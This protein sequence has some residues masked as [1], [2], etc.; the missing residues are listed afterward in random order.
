MATLVQQLYN[1]VVLGGV[2]VLVALGITL[3]YGL[4]RLVNF[5][6]GQM[7]T[8]GAFI[9][10]SLVQLH[11]PLLVAIPLSMV[12]VALVGELL[13]LTLFRRTLHRPLSGLIISLGLIA[14]FEAFFVL[15]W[16]TNSYQLT[17]PFSAIWVLGGV[18]VDETRLLELLVTLGACLFF[19]FALERTDL[20]VATRALAEDGLAARALGVPVSR[21][22]S[23]TFLVGS[24]MAALAGAMLG[25]I[26]VFD[27]YSGSAFL[28]K[29]FAVAI[30]GG[31]G[32]V[33]G[34]V[35]AGLILGVAETLGGGYI[36][37]E[38]SAAFGLGTMALILA[39]RPQGLFRGT[40]GASEE[41]FGSGWAVATADTVPERDRGRV[42][43]AA[44]AVQPVL[45]AAAIV[46]L[47]P[48]VLPNAR[49]LSIATSALI[50]ATIAFALWLTM[51]YAGMLSVVQGALMGVG[52]YTAGILAERMGLGFWA[53][54]PAAAV[55]G[56]LVA[57][58]MGFLSLRGTATGFVILT[59]A[60]SELIVTIFTNWISLTGGAIGLV[61]GRSPG[62]LGPVDFSDNLVFYYLISGLL[63]LV[64]T[65]SAALRYTSFG[66]KLITIRDNERLAR[67]LGLDTTRYKL[68]IFAVGGAVAAIGG[69]L[70]LYH[71]RFV[72]PS[73]FDV[74]TAINVQLVV[75]LGGVASPAGPIIGALI[76][77]FLPE[78]LRL[79]PTQAQLAYGV[80]LVLMA[81][82]LPQGVVGAWNGVLA[83]TRSLTRL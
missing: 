3:I 80:L 33:R 19:F 73:L 18:R 54:L 6:H 39:I 35:V 22:I 32:N 7:L 23:V 79:D 21:L 44:R 38:W 72:E 81:T 51:H 65:L 43:A 24:G 11:I 48:V 68:A 2:Y 71:F 62:R 9:S 16:S 49:E 50:L 42:R 76:V 13:D 57:V 29:G 1:G 8:L 10:F 61:I 12:V 70:T 64:L 37:I 60:L 59:F 20:G 40:E 77:S 58:V 78:L 41:S 55:L 69:Q 63:L 66:R 30:I 52:A 45:I 47:L 4:T 46:V 67:S 56:M 26:F 27:A 74:F 25:T 15:R 31:L 75:I 5:A 82:F 83:R 36:S 28:L 17:S 34:A 14:A 53:E